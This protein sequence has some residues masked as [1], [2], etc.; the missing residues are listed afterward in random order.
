MTVHTPSGWWLSIRRDGSAGLGYG[1]TAG[2]G[3]SLQPRSFSFEDVHKKLSALRFDGA[4]LSHD[5][6]VVFRERDAVATYALS[7]SDHQAIRELFREAR[8]RAKDFDGTGRLASIW[9]DHLPVP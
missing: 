4:G 6:S 2:D 5:P 1:S 3:I 8:D 7:T 9:A